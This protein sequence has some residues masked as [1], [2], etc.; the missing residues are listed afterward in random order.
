MHI[1]FVELLQL[2]EWCLSRLNVSHLLHTPAWA[3]Y[4][5]TGNS[6]ADVIVNF[7]SQL[8][9][10]FLLFWGMVMSANEFE[11]NEK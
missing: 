7:S 5:V 1:S 4:T 9:F 2:W 8:I 3:P 10:V 11:T 6:H